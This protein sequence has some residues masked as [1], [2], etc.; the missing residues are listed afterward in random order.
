MNRVSKPIAACLSAAM[1]V[2]CGGN[3]HAL[4]PSVPL[5]ARFSPRSLSTQTLQRLTSGGKF[6]ATYSGR[7]RTSCYAEIDC[8]FSLKGTGYGTFIQASTLQSTD[9]ICQEE[10]SWRS[11]L[12][13][14]SAGGSQDNLYVAAFGNPKVCKHSERLRG[15][16]TITGGTGKFASA[17]GSGSV[18]IYL[19]ARTFEAHFSGMIMF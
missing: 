15:S 1:L 2:A 19:E 13:I 3:S 9:G 10:I 4:S 5:T 11:S 18:T 6:T 17:S 12:T 16:Y 7:A 8:S 14:T